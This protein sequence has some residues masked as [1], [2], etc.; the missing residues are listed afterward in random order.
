MD[1][2]FET[3]SLAQIG[4]KPIMELRIIL[5]FSSFVLRLQTCNTM[6]CSWGDGVCACWPGSLPA[7]LHSHCCSLVLGEKEPQWTEKPTLEVLLIG[8]AKRGSRKPGLEREVRRVR[9]TGGVLF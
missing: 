8:C 3:L 5:N 2:P 4:L 6:S 1:F 9:G 7:E